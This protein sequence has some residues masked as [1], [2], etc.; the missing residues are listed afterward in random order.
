[1]VLLHKRPSWSPAHDGPLA[2]PLTVYLIDRGRYTR[3][4]YGASFLDPVLLGNDIASLALEHAG[5][6]AR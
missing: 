5:C 2:L 4:L 6:I 1:V 3:N